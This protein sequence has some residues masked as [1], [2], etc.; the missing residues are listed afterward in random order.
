MLVDFIKLILIEE[1]VFSQKAQ[2]LYDV[3]IHPVKKKVDCVNYFTIKTYK[4]EVI[5][6]F[7]SLSPS[8]RHVDHS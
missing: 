3:F 4:F 2:V 5:G 8:T 1:Y 6:D 7:L